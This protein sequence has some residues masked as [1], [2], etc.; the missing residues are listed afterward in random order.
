MNKWQWVDLF[1][2]DGIDRLIAALSA[3]ATALGGQINDF[4][5]EASKRG[6]AIGTDLSHKVGAFTKV[7]AVK[8]GISFVWVRSTKGANWI[9]P[10]FQHHW[11]EAERAGVR[12]GAYHVLDIADDI[13]S[14]ARSFLN[15]AKI[16]RNDLPPL[17][18]L[19]ACIVDDFLSFSPEA[20][21]DRIRSCLS[22]IRSLSMRE[23]I[24]Y[25]RATLWDACMPEGM[26]RVRLF[27]GCCDLVGSP[28]LPRGWQTWAFWHH[29]MYAQVEGLV[30]SVDIY[31]FNGSEQEL[32]A[33][34]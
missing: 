20:R 9:D 16:G 1:R 10:S 4:T 14:Q 27:T 15:V 17:L 21:F 25:T 30:G 29:K 23:P 24:I 26:P 6:H 28:C 12:R 11:L 18:S 22:Y 3:R 32:A 34:A 2:P 13:E 33:F 19:E 31:S 5:R 8:A 7:F